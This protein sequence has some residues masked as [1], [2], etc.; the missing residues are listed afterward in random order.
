M[1][2]GTGAN[3]PRGTDRCA[4][5]VVAP[6]VKNYYIVG[7]RRMRIGSA[8][9]STSRAWLLRRPFNDKPERC[10]RGG[11]CSPHFSFRN[12][13]PFDCCG[14]ATCT[15]SSTWIWSPSMTAAPRGPR[16]LATDPYALETV[17]DRCGADCAI[18]GDART[19][20]AA[21][22]RTTFRLVVFV[23]MVKFPSTFII[24]RRPVLTG[25]FAVS[26]ERREVGGTRQA[27]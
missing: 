4:G 24:R 16:V 18:T 11:V 6:C 7:R 14:N 1:R 10:G 12:H 17:A 26:S 9:S 13:I 19:A 15:A 3:A 20:I 8:R 23:D 2:R 21:A 25:A 27:N 22:A 5:S